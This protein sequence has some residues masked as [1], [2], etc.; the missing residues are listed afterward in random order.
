MSP[1]QVLQQIFGYR[2]FRPG[3]QQV[4]E[5]AIAGYDSLV[6]M[7]TGGGKSL[8]YQVP[9]LATQGLTVVV[10]PLL[11]LMK[12]QVDS[13]VQLGVNAAYLNSSVANDE[14]AAIM[15]Q[16]NNGQL[17]LL[18][19]S[20]ERLGR[21]HL[22][23]RLSYCNV[24][25]FAIDEA[26]CISQWGHEF[27]PDYQA[28]GRIKVNFPRTPIMALT[29]TADQATRD[30]ILR[31][32]GLTNPNVHLSSFDR[33]NIRYEVVEKLNAFEQLKSF[34]IS[35]KGNSGIIYCGS[36]R[37]VDDLTE[38]LLR[39]GY[40]V[41]GYHAGLDSQQRAWAH[42]SFIK[43]RV[44]IVVA[45]VAFG[46]GIDKPNVRFVVHYD[47]PKSI[48]SYYQETGRAGRDGSASEALMLYDPSD[49]A[50]VRQFISE[51]DS[52]QARVELHK[53]NSMQAFAEAQTCRRQVLL[54]YFDEPSHK[55]CG[56]CDVCLDPPQKFDG[57]EVAQK[58]LSCIYRL[59]QSFGIGYVIEVLMGSKNQRIIERG[60]EKLSTWGLGK[61]KSNEFWLSIIRQLIHHGLVTQNITR[62][63]VLTL[64][65]AARA[66][67]KGDMPLELA[68]PRLQF[69]KKAFK[70]SVGNLNY[71][72]KLYS[73]LKHLRREL[74]AEK[75]L[76]PY[77]IFNDATLME[78][79]AIIPTTPDQMLTV[80][81]V[82]QTKL[83]RYGHHFLQEIET[84]L[85]KN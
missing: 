2:D 38:R 16:V 74:A 47:I 29:A 80:N 7:P 70:S 55:P 57:T 42:E 46:M 65:V 25:L 32:L 18:Y 13:L 71:D 68:K 37:K 17:K 36:R 24:A 72:K 64:N 35:Q 40:K 73:T 54:N 61:D 85:S 11:S 62:S 9:A 1:Q 45:T 15:E 83:Q 14:Q 20:P 82:G 5:T 50:R 48:E 30:D 41:A 58:A 22:M 12:D 10:S 66:V 6:I 53:L 77:L 81:G 56:N 19:V 44:E 51:N 78:M 39:A 4:I 49:I 69:T 27:R 33:P 84:Y 28:L 8:C 3:Q 21:G 26:H 43:D 79:A 52:A 59:Q 67:L 34:L 23:Q 60:H 31:C 63:S 76:A 75:N